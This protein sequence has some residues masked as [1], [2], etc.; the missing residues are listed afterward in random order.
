[1]L[2]YQARAMQRG[3]AKLGEASLLDGVNC[4]H[5]NLQRDV[6]VYAGIGDNADDN[7]VVRYDMAALS[8]DCNPRVGQRLVHPDGDYRLDRLVDDNRFVRRFI[9]VPVIV[10]IPDLGATYGIADSA[11]ADL[12]AEYVVEAE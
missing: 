5:V 10:A 11:S 9:V 2:G 6:L 3:L 7:P 8:V 1:M 12:S 4:G